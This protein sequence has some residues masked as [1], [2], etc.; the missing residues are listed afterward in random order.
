MPGGEGRELA[1]DFGPWRARATVPGLRAAP[2]MPPPG[3][4]EGGRGAVG[5]SAGL[6]KVHVPFAICQFVAFCLSA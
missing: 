1:P 3:G 4:G 2:G 6:I 5:V